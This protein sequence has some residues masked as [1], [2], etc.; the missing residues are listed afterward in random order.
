MAYSRPNNRG[1]ALGRIRRYLPKRREAEIVLDA[2]L[3]TGDTIEV[4]ASVGGRVATVVREMWV[5]GRPAK[6]APPGAAVTLPLAGRV[7]PGDRVFK[8]E[9]AAL[10]RRARETFTSPREQKNIPLTF[11]VSVREGVPLKLEVTDPGGFSVTAES[12]VPAVRAERRPL[13]ADTLKA[14]LGRLGNTP[15]G[16]GKL[17]C[18][19][20]GEVMLPLRELNEVRRRALERLEAVKITARRPPALEA[21]DFER[22]L[23]GYL[24]K[25]PVRIFSRPERPRLTVAVGNLAGVTAAVEAGA[26]VVYF[27][28]E[29]LG[30]ARTIGFEQ[31]VEA[32]D[33]CRRGGASLVLWLPRILHDRDLVR[34]D[35]LLAESDRF[36][37]GVLAGNPG[38]FLMAGGRPE[39]VADFPLNIFN[40][41]TLSLLAELGATRVTLSLELTLEQVRE[42]A[43]NAPVPVEVLVHGALPVMVSEYCVVGSLLDPEDGDRCTVRCRTGRFALR[44]RLGLRFPVG[45]DSA[46]RMHVFNA[47]DL[48]AVEQVPALIRCGVAAFRVEGR[49]RDAAYLRG[50]VEIYREVIDRCLSRGPDWRVPPRYKE[51][52]RDFSPQ[53]L[54]SGHYFRG[55][56]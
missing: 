47:K 8:T 29:G 13:T 17:D 11:K 41:L 38:V 25:R 15:F 9:D 42:L 43:A 23:R 22:R 35:Q 6:A 51:R 19:I 24:Q 37:S 3:N 27:P 55:V 44:D 16:L 28:G 12:A 49:L 50:V 46:C 5:D 56:L 54:T 30:A 21:S 18:R 52:L 26:D 31:L 45:V 48:C 1:L 7:R 53:G 33:V 4:W 32:G 36:I 14:Q 20:E 34:W 40:R 39:L 2:P 10:E